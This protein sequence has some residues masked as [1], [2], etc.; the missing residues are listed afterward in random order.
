[1]NQSINQSTDQYIIFPVVWGPDSGLREHGAD[2]TILNWQLGSGNPSA[3]THAHTLAILISS[4][5][6]S[7]LIDAN[8]VRDATT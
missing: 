8:E 1:M 4:W 6:R 2:E 5:T 3:I 7:R